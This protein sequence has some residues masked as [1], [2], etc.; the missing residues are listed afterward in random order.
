MAHKTVGR[1]AAVSGVSVRALHH[2]DEIGLLRPEGRSAAGYRLYGD[3]DLLRLQEILVWRSAGFPLDEIAALLDDPDRDPGEALRTHRDRLLAERGA[4][5][6]QLQA[7]DR[8]L[9]ARGTAAPLQDADLAAV[10]EG[11]DPAAHEAEA[12]ARWGDTPA[13]AEAQR[14][15]RSYGPEEWARI[16]AESA[17]LEARLAAC[18]QAGAPADA[19]EALQAARDH[20]A[21]IERWFYECPPE[22][23]RGLANLYVG[24]PRFSAHY[25]RTAPGLARYLSDA[26]HALHGPAPRT[27]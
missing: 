22:V 19:P 16:R 7:L 17:E 4:L 18:L 24:N 10:F 25:E 15:T 20:R 9:A 12:E 6:A 26:V 23:H 5:D 21:H 11:F 13:W 14:R 27:L 8:I 1:V 3:E 2:Y